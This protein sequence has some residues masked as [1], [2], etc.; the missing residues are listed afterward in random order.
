[1]VKLVMQIQLIFRIAQVKK[2]LIQFLLL[3][4]NTAV[5]NK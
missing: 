4:H 5:L 2:D 3:T 1:M